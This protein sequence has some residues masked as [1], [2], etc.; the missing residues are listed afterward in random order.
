[1]KISLRQVYDRLF[2][3]FGPQHWWPGETAFEVMVGAVLVQNT[4]WKNVK[5]AIDNLR[6][7]GLLEPRRLYE[8]PVEQ[9]EELIRPAGYFRLKTQRLRHLLQ[10]LV[11][12]H[13]GS[14]ERMFRTNWRTL[15]E[16]LLAVHGIGPETADSILLYAGRVPVFVIDAYTYR[17]MTRH[18]WIEPEAD[19]YALQEHFAAN[20]EE[21]EALFNEFHALIVRLGHLH[22]RKTPKCE[23]CPLAEFLPGGR[24]DMSF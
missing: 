4:A 2:S 13:H 5:K 23:G 8:L 1:M 19:Y 3:A 12:E 22:C 10:F 14:V 7:G 21:D 16:Q 18:G 9:L 24:P 6:A 11:E 17:M 15:R 20:L